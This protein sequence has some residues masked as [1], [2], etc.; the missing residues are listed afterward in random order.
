LRRC[1]IRGQSV[2]NCSSISMSHSNLHDWR[3]YLGCY[4]CIDPLGLPN[5]RTDKCQADLAAKLSDWTML[6]GWTIQNDSRQHPIKK[7]RQK[8]SDSLTQVST[9][10]TIRQFKFL[11]KLGLDCW[12]LDSELCEKESVYS[13]RAD[14]S[15]PK[16][17]W[18]TMNDKFLQAKAE[19]TAAKAGPPHGRTKSKTGSFWFQS[20]Q[21]QP[22]SPKTI[23]RTSQRGA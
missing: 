9:G 1:S 2:L 11:R 15:R 6:I 5:A 4:D 12:R 23:S 3:V 8:G 16:T 22:E 18:M 17:V 7:E 20:T 19:K 21:L 13:N 10:Q 14:D